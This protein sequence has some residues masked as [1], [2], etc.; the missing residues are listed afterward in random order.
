MPMIQRG[1]AHRRFDQ[2]E[3]EESTH[4]AKKDPHC[5]VIDLVEQISLDGTGQ[6]QLQNQPS[7]PKKIKVCQHQQD[8][9]SPF[10]P[11]SELPD[12]KTKEQPVSENS[13]EHKTG[14]PKILRV[15]RHQHSPKE[16]DRN[17]TQNLG[18]DRFVQAE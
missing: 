16:G 15:K 12:E 6:S 8:F 10:A 3:G 13:E 4:E 1:I 17:G 18:I 5:I 11:F 9:P 7:T 14:N 2:I